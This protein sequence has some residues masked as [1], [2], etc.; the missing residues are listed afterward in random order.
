MTYLEP[1]ICRLDDF[2]DTMLW[3]ASREA[4]PATPERIANA[5]QESLFDEKPSD[6]VVDVLRRIPD[7]PVLTK[8]SAQAWSKEV[9]VPYILLT[10]GANPASAEEPFLKNIWNHRGVKSVATFRSRLES[11]VTDFLTRYSRERDPSTY[12]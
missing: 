1:L 4:E 9:I 8:G 12:S 10:D 3:I 11:A 7:L 5:W 6:A 2:R